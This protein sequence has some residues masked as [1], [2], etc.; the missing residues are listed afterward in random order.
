VFRQCGY[1][2]MAGLPPLTILVVREDSGLPGAGFVAAADIPK[3]QI[4]V[5]AYDWL[6]KGAPSP[7][8]LEQA[9][10]KMPVTLRAFP[11]TL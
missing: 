3:T 4:K 2:M 9:V 6:E 5:F 11:W 1:C 8:A 10:A 7:E